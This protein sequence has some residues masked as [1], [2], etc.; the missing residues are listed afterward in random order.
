MRIFEIIFLT[1][2]NKDTMQT[3]KA[4]ILEK[5][6]IFRII[7]K[8]QLHPVKLELLSKIENKNKLN[9]KLLCFRDSLDLISI[10][11]KFGSLIQFNEYEKCNKNPHKSFNILKFS[12]HEFSRIIYKIDKKKKKIEIFF[13][14][15]WNVIEINVLFYIKQIFIN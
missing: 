10:S 9:I 15:L 12:L 2:E 7:Y 6:S 8:N 3:F 1:K 4:F 14:N 5:R 13:R 11:K